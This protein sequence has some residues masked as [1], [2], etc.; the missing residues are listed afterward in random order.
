MSQTGKPTPAERKAQIERDR[1]RREDENRR[2]EL[3]REKLARAESEEL[4]A[5]EAI[6][7]EEERK[8]KEA[9]EMM[10]AAVAA[11]AKRQEE[12]LAATA[13]EIEEEERQAD[14]KSRK[15]RAGGAIVR[16]QHEVGLIVGK[17][18][19]GKIFSP[20]RKPTKRPRTIES[21][22]EGE[23]VEIADD[24]KSDDDWETASGS[25]TGK[26]KGKGKKKAQRMAVNSPSCDWC[27]HRNI[28]R[29]SGP[30]TKLIIK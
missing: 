11:E 4:R 2:A 7:A 16:H 9:E 22:E 18:P 6:E 27:A 8:R 23:V 24:S 26:G 13:A 3:E 10:A 29:G 30:G 1:K 28:V 21:S 19:R 15:V 12:E 20:V 5:I 25:K 14:K 17:T